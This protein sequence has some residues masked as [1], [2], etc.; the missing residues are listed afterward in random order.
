MMQKAPPGL[1]AGGKK[2]WSAVC[3]D[4]ELAAHELSVLLQ[5]CRTV[6]SLD[7]LEE[8]VRAEGVTAE[9]SQGARVH[10]CLVEAR[11]QRLALAK[12]LASL[13]IPVDDAEDAGRLPQ[14]RG[15]VRPAGLSVAR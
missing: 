6:D 10:P 12:L 15:G 8:V 7:A 2:L 13:R 14:R 3:E 1:R 9:S 5:A 11:Q 4:Y